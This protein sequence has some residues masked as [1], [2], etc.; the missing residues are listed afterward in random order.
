MQFR[1]EYPVGVPCWVDIASPDPQATA[2]FYADLF[3][4]ELDQRGDYLVGRRYDGDVAG[5]GRLVPGDSTATW[6]MYVRV[7]D[8]ADAARNVP[9]AG[10]TVVSGPH[11]APGIGRVVV[12]ADRQGAQFRLFEPAGLTGAQR[13]NAPGTWNFNELNTNDAEAAAGFYGAMFGWRA[14][15]LAY[16]GEEFQMWTRPG[17]GDFLETIDP[18]VKQR[19]REGGAP[20]DF[21]DAVAWLQ[22]LP[23][24]AEPHWSVTFSVDDTEAVAERAERLGGSV[25]VPPF[26]A[27]VAIVAQLSDPAGGRF[28]ASKFLG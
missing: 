17:Y 4:W 18:G 23:A 11:D 9:A 15:P 25:L 26:N 2:R 21:S 27:G 13:V 12:C 8:V 5:I 20:P 6:N 19:H 10:G 24:G 22:G 16:A 7:A 14:H 3:D 1:N 28:T